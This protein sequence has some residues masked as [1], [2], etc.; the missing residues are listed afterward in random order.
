MMFGWLSIKSNSLN[1]W[2]SINAFANEVSMSVER[3]SNMIVPWESLEL[4]SHPHE[5]ISIVRIAGQIDDTCF[6][7][8][9]LMEDTHYMYHE[10]GA[11]GRCRIAIGIAQG[12]ENV[13]YVCPP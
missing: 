9:A 10:Y 13:R 4:L 8:K 3:L 6:I 11:D 12:V 2:L 7:F 5:N 1:S